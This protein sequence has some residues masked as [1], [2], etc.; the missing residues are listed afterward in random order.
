[1]IWSLACADDIVLVAKNRKALTDMMDT[2]KV[3]LKERA[4]ELNI[5]KTNFMVFNKKGKEKR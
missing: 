4:L 1:M 2:L 3:F 5:D